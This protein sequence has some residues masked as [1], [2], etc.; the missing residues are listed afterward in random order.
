M[1]VPGRLITAPHFSPPIQPRADGARSHHRRRRAGG[2]GR[3]EEIERG[4]RVGISA[5]LCLFPQLNQ[6]QLFSLTSPLNCCQGVNA[7]GVSVFSAARKQ[8]RRNGAARAGARR[9]SNIAT[10]EII[11]SSCSR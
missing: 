7:L 9:S 10:W 11:K 3:E 8:D 2:G 4:G 5:S 6:S 1:V